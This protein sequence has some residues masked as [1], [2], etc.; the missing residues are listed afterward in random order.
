VSR[1][2]HLNR[3]QRV[4]LVI[5]L[6]GAF[7]FVGSYVTALGLRSGWVGYAPLSSQAYAP[8]TSESFSDLHPWVRLVVWVGL[9]VIWAVSSVALLRSRSSGE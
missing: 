6:A 1:V 4:V 2:P 8:L 9:T 5:A 7:Y 3:G